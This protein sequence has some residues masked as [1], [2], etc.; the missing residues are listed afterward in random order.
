MHFK[1]LQAGSDAQIVLR[2]LAICLPIGVGASVGLWMLVRGLMYGWR[3]ADDSIT[4]GIILG[5]LIG[6][7]LT[8]FV[9]G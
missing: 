5:I 9:A 1:N 3:Y 4:A 8:A 7:N 6:S 2:C